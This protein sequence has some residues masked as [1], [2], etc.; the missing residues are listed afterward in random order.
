MLSPTQPAPPALFKAASP[1]LKQLSGAMVVLT[2]CKVEAELTST[3][4]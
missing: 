2:R 1:L 3:K 4:H